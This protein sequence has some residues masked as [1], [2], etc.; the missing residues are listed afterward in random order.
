MVRQSG[1]N[2]IHYTNQPSTIHNLDGTATEVQG[3]TTLAPISQPWTEYQTHRFDWSSDQVTFY[4]GPTAVWSSSVNVP[5][6][7]GTMNLNVW[8]NGGTWTGY[9]SK[10]DVLFRV[11]KIAMYHNTTA[12]Q[13]GND[14]AFN[15]RCW[16]AG[17]LDANTVCMDEG[18]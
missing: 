17:G 8:A 15:E 10:T 2:N 18:P 5:Q 16:A 11:Q 13:V 12:S 9:P 6:V 14:W 7:G 4:Q 3:S 1:L